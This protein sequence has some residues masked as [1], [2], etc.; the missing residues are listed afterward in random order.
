MQ[1]W[2]TPNATLAFQQCTP[3]QILKVVGNQRFNG[4]SAMALKWLRRSKHKESKP[5]PTEPELTKPKQT[6]QS[7]ASLREIT[8]L[9]RKL[10]EM[11]QKNEENAHVILRLRNE[12]FETRTQNENLQNE[13]E[14]LKKTI[15]TLE[16]QLKRLKKKRARV[17]QKV[18]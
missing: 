12:S 18:Q 14:V 3:Q 8:R 7:M 13:R 15:R 10:A 1:S 11:T 16:Q 9:K 2:L 4:E 5:K 6:K 17:F